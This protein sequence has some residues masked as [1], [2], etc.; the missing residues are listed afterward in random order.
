[1]VHIINIVVLPTVFD[2]ESNQTTLSYAYCVDID[3]I[4]YIDNDIADHVTCILLF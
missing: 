1:V 2:Y 3:C 4:S